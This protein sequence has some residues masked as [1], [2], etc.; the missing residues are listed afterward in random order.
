MTSTTLT[1]PD[2]THG[3]L[4][5]PALLVMALIGFVLLATETMPAG[6]LPQIASGMNTG[7]GAA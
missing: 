3:R 7:E 4:P 6:L 2:T 5:L 1:P